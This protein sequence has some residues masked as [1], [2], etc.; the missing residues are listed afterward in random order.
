MIRILAIAL[1]SLSLTASGA[2]S[3]SF[4][5]LIE[6]EGLY[7][8]KF[9]DEPFTGSL[10]EGESWGVLKNGKREGPWVTDYVNGQLSWK[11][12]FKSGKREG[13][14][15]AYWANGQLRFKGAYKNGDREGPWV[16]YNSDGTKDQARSGTYRNVEKVSD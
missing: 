16:G 3:T 11:G 1:L 13:P 14:W 15:V 10:D 7:Y 2:F 12:V 8:K 4:N 9:T 6:R 5:D